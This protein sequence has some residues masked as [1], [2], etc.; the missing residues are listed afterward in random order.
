MKTFVFCTDL[1][2]DNQN[3]D[4]VAALLKFTDDLFRPDIRIFGG[5]LFDF[6]NIR[7]GVGAAERQDS[8]AN[9]VDAGLEFLRAFK[10]NIF[11]LGNHDA[12]LWETAK[13]HE[14]GIVRDAAQNGVRDIEARCRQL[15]C[16]ILPYESNKGFFDLGKV[17]FIH[18]YHTGIYATKKH[19]EIYSPPGGIVLH[20]HTH[21]IQL[22]S[23]P[24]LGGGRG[25]GVGCLA[26]LDMDY[27]KSHTARMSHSHGFAYGYVDKK[28]DWE[29]Y[30][31][32]KGGSGW[33][34]AKEL[35]TIPVGPLN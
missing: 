20:G 34:V 16:K 18:G 9:D 21:A 3:R 8:M 28:N 29:V 22:H 11:L 31:A 26:R 19:A 13:F 27:N 24:R 35:I 32:K 25:M 1:H 7:K 23:I 10:P 30:Q 2:G 6:R 5:D 33:V 15:K 4:A 17:R 12:R 14:S